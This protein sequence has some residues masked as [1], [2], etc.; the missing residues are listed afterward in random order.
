MPPPG[1]SSHSIKICFLTRVR[2]AT[3]SQSHAQSRQCQ[4]RHDCNSPDER[5]LGE[6]LGYVRSLNSGG[7]SGRAAAGLRVF[8]D[9]RNLG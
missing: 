3:K 8:G 7:R 4:Q 6:L 2:G 9:T 1:N 5:D